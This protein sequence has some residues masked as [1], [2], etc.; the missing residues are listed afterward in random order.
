MI[1]RAIFSVI[2]MAMVGFLVYAIASAD[3]YTNGLLGIFPTKEEETV[4]VDEL[5]TEI[6]DLKAYIYELEKQIEEYEDML[7]KNRK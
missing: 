6:T 3:K 1:K 5:Q 2:I 4:T 7:P